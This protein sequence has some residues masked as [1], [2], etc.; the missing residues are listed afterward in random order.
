M[1]Y[2]LAFSKCSITLVIAV[3]AEINTFTNLEHFHSCSYSAPLL[4]ELLNL[5]ATVKPGAPL[6]LL[7]FFDL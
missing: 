4:L 3:I 5:T 1:A 7:N 2:A 6:I